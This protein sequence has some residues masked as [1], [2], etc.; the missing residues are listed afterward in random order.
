VPEPAVTVDAGGGAA[1]PPPVSVPGDL[2]VY[3]RAAFLDRVAAFAIDAILV[4][5]A[6]NL[7]DLERH[8]GYF[9]LLLLAYHVAFWAWRGT[10]LGG[11][12][13][14]LRVVRVQG[15]DLRF[16]DALVRG[17]TAV[18]SIAAL[19]IGCFWMINDPEKQMWHDKIAGT[20]VVKVPRHLVLP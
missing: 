15:S 1:P 11:I 2:G 17:L 13:V 16:A 7:L 20:F 12:I 10:T 6:V 5:I 9:P 3:P 4:A 14:G 18:F 19:G 8:D